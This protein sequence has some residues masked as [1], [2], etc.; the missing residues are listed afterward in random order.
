MFNNMT[1]F[2]KTGLEQL[3][4]TNLKTNDYNILSS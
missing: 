3:S 1:D 2:R 4:Y